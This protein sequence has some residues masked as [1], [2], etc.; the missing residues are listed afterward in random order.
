[1]FLFLS[2]CTTSIVA[3]FTLHFHALSFRCQEER[4]ASYNKN[5]NY[6][7]KPSTNRHAPLTRRSQPTPCNLKLIKMQN[8]VSHRKVDPVLHS[9]V[10]LFG[11]SIHESGCDNLL[12]SWTGVKA[13]RSRSPLSRGPPFCWP[14]VEHK[15]SL[16]NAL[17]CCVYRALSFP[18]GPKAC[19]T[20]W[21]VLK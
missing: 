2:S 12:A 18:F 10:F 4:R 21:R 19:N 13:R 17:R 8:Q 5:K 9:Y 15:Y 7:K 16:Q 1:M 11:L 3:N 20:D 6:F 14:H